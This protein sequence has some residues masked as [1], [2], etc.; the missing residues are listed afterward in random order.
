MDRL[1]DWARDTAYAVVCAA[2]VLSCLLVTAGD[3]RAEGGQSCQDS[4]SALGLVGQQYAQCINQCC[5]ANPQQ[6]AFTSC[7]GGNPACAVYTTS[8]DC[9]P[10]DIHHNDNCNSNTNCNCRW[11]N[12]KCYCANTTGN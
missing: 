5:Q 3:L 1:R 9:W 2:A 4:C 11:N 6:C 7:S 10:G 12:T 8:S